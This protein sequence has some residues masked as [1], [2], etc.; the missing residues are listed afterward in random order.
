[1]NE[2]LDQPCDPNAS[3]TNTAGSYSCACNVNYSG[4]GKTCTKIAS[5]TPSTKQVSS[6]SPMSGALVSII[7]A[8]FVMLVL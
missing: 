4:D 8:L 7:V 3:C 1:M 6:A 5:P 2:C